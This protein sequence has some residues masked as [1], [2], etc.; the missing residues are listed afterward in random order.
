MKRILALTALIAIFVVI[1][2]PAAI[3]LAAGSWNIAVINSTAT[4][5]PMLPLYIGSNNTYM[6][7]GG[8]FTDANG[9]DAQII[10]G[11]TTY[12]R[13][14][15]SNATYFAMPVPASSS[16]IVQLATGQSATDFA[17]IPGTGG[18]VTV[19]DSASLEL[20]NNFTINASVCLPYSGSS[21][22]CTAGTI[23]TVAATMSNGTGNITFP[24]GYAGYPTVS[25]NSTGSGTSTGPSISLPA[26]TTNGD[27]LLVVISTIDKTFAKTTM[28]ATANWTQLYQTM[29]GS[30]ST[31]AAWY[32]VAS[33]EP[34]SYTWTF[35]HNSDYGYVVLR[36]SAGTYTGVPVC[37]VASNG[38][39]SNP[40]PPSLTS[41]F[42]NVPTLWI[43]TTDSYAAQASAPANYAGLLQ[44]GTGNAYSVTAQ[45]QYTSTSENPGT[46]GTSTNFWCGE[47][48]AVQGSVPSATAAVN[49]TSGEHFISVVADGT[50]TRC[51]LD[52]V[53]SANYSIIGFSTGTSNWTIGAGCLYLNSVNISVGGTLKLSF[54]PNTIIN[55]TTRTLT[56]RSGNG[57]HG[58]I[59]FGTFTGATA[60][61]SGS[62]T[63][64][65]APVTQGEQDIVPGEVH[66]KEVPSVPAQTLRLQKDLMYPA[67][68]V[69]SDFTGW[70]LAF[71]YGLGLFLAGLVGFVLVYGSSRHLALSTLPL[72]LTTGYGSAIL[73]YYWIVLAC[74]ILFAIGCIVMEG[75]QSPV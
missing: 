52:G 66:P 51:L 2:L 57:N 18:N 3:S 4:A 8:Y 31:T 25:N 43:A 45:R 60:I 29:H 42:G 50:N 24:Y 73:A 21:N 69:I 11:V 1:T 20:G 63:P 48:I 53:S 72:I 61:I 19:P 17:I 49:T 9:R 59:N 7:S 15:A 13:M 26:G 36:I 32:R 12:P 71:T 46:F 74:V 65:A 10:Q 37:G 40:D 39:G 68:K 30:Y 70:P 34:A 44:S 54:Q 67:F 75:R 55:S 33:S 47:T 5:Y 6:A 14:L 23:Y 41:G 56:D 35:D 22:I 62:F 38:S 28:T 64:A 27:L 58:T 16:Q